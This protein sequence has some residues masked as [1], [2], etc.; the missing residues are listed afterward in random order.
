MMEAETRP[1]DASLLFAVSVKAATVI[2]MLRVNVSK[3]TWRTLLDTHS[4]TPATSRVISKLR[5]FP[6]NMLLGSLTRL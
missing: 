1:A 3:A 4:I 6:L 5:K 2:K